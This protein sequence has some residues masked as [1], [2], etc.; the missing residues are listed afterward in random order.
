MTLNTILGRPLLI[1]LTLT[2]A[3][4]GSTSKDTAAP[5]V[6]GAGDDDDD[7]DDDDDTSDTSGGG[8]AAPFVP[9]Y[10][11][12]GLGTFAID[13]SSGQMVSA[14]QDGGDPIPLQVLVVFYAESVFDS[15]VAN[16]SNSCSVVLSHPGPIDATPVKGSWVGN[17]GLLAGLTMPADATV[18]SA[19]GNIEDAAFANLGTDLLNFSWGVGVGLMTPS[20]DTELAGIFGADWASLQPYAGQ[21]GWYVDLLEGSSFAPAGYMDT[22][23]AIAILTDADNTIQVDDSGYAVLLASGDLDAGGVAANAYYEVSPLGLIGPANLLVQ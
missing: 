20:L 12:V 14:Q 2:L 15:G 11:G 23:Y 13:P 17:S 18:E 22:G 5:T 19:C 10:F 4:C 6:T 8:G 7:D 21:G 3:A 1:A 9:D 16:E